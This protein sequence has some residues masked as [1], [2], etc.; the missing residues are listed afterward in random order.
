VLKDLH[1]VEMTP[2]VLRHAVGELRAPLYGWDGR[3]ARKILLLEDLDGADLCPDGAPTVSLQAARPDLRLGG[4]SDG[5]EFLSRRSPSC[6]P[7]SAIARGAWQ[8]GVLCSKTFT[9]HASA[10]PALR[11]VKA[12]RPDLRS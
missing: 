6:A 9:E 5:G 2:T 7:R 4:A 11:R 3:V 8:G 12:A 1:R 10:A